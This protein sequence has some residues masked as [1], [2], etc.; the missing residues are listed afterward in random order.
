[1]GFKQ[2]VKVV[3]LLGAMITSEGDDNKTGC[4]PN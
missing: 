4:P 1:M 3:T 2:C